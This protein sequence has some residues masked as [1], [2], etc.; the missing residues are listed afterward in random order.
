MR[1]NIFHSN[2][3]TRK[4]DQPYFRIAIIRKGYTTKYCSEFYYLLSVSV[5]SSPSNLIL[6]LMPILNLL[7]MASK[8][9]LTPMI[10]WLVLNKQKAH[11]NNDLLSIYHLQSSSKNSKISTVAYNILRKESELQQHERP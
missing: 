1:R 9:L 6:N 10:N 5:E 7:L 2:Y 3:G 8:Y 11:V 4:S